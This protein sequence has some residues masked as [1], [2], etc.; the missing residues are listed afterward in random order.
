MDSIAETHSHESGRNER[1]HTRKTKVTV[2]GRF[3][4]S[5]QWSLHFEVTKSMDRALQR[6]DPSLT[7]I[8]A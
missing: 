3:F 4:A 2:A 1:G 5:Q 8:A 7:S 6:S